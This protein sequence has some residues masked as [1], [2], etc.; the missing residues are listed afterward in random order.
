LMR[1]FIL[2][3]ALV[4]TTQSMSQD[5]TNRWTLRKCVDYAVQNNITVKQADIQR[6]YA[7][8]DLHQSQ[9]TKY[10]TATGQLSGG[11][12]FG[13]S[14]NPATGT[15]E[16]N[17][18]FAAQGSFQTNY[19]LFNWGARKNNIEADKLALKASVAGI[20]KAQN[21]ISLSVANT[22]LQAMLANETIRIAELQ[23]RQSKEQLRRTE[24]LVRS[25]TEPELNSLQ[26]QAQVANDSASLIQALSTYR[27][28]LIQLKTLLN[29]PQD[30]TFEIITPP[31]EL[32][33]LESLADLNPEYVYNLAVA[34]QP[35]QRVNQ[36]R[37]Q[38]G[39]RLIRAA[40]GAM[41]P[42]IGAQGSLSTSY[43]A[44]QYPLMGFTGG[45]DTSFAFV[46]TG[47][48]TYNV[49]SPKRDQVGT[50]RVPFRRQVSNNF[51][52]FIGV[53]VTFNLFN[54][55]QLRSQWQRAKIQ[56]MQ[57]EL[58]QL[59][60]NNTLQSDIYNAY[61]LSVAALQ[62]FNASVRQVEVNERALEL[63]NKRYEAGLLNVLDLLITQTNLQRARI[64]MARN[65]YDYIFKMKVLE[66]YKGMGIRL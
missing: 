13:L 7:E 54:Q 61:E 3:L 34:N 14:N 35:L 21:D 33:P 51:G 9:M 50:F 22:F 38:Q 31:V 15:L 23:L 63:A 58:Q 62:K 8:V 40:R 20:E 36:I 26:L 55:H 66:F 18:F 57:Y 37:I 56:V 10:P 47:S 32:I 6:R 25:G 45:Y 59:Q 27:Q 24:A 46:N 11:Y 44:I 60:D 64:E 1:L 29:L 52:Q 5:T 12:N 43:T 4:L 2:P 53:G 30:T 49:I 48:G 41:Y 28:S 16:T 65:R 17:N 19:S 39:E 42:A